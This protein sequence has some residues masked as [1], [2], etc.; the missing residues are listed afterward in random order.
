MNDR[1]LAAELVRRMNK[2]I[3]TDP[4]AQLVLSWLMKTRIEVPPELIDHPTI[5]V[6]T[7]IDGPPKVGFLGMLNGI[8]GVI[9]EGN[10]EDWGHVTARV[11]DGLILRFELTQL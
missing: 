4:I 9:P 1:T 11:E 8:V 10:H 2:L 5:Q 3:D 7:R 6:D